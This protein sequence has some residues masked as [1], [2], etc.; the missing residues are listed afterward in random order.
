[1]NERLTALLNHPRTQAVLT[2]IRQWRKEL[3]VVLAMLLTM[4][5]P[6]LLKPAQSTAP[7]R[8]DR[9]LV[10]ISP[11]HDRIREEFGQAFAAHW[12]QST[13]QTLFIDWRVPGG[14]SEIAMLI[15]SE[16]S[17][18]FQQ[19]WQSK[20]KQAWSPAVAQAC[21]NPKAA[22]E[23]AARQAY[24]ASNLTT[25]MD[26]FFGGG[27]YDFEQQAK[28][29]TLVAGDGEKTG[30][31]GLTKKHPEWFGENGIPEKLSGEPFRDPQGRWCG[32]CLSSSGIVFNRD[33]LRRIGIA[34]DPDAWEDLADPRY[35]GQ[36]AL[37]DPGKSGS[38]TK[39]LEMLIQQQMQIAID[40]LKAVPN[41]KLTP[42]EL[43]AEG[44]AAGWNEGLRLILRISANARY[45]TDFSTKIPLEVARGDAGA[46]MCIDFYGRSAEEDVRKA[47]GTSR[48]GFIAPLGGTSIS[49]DPIGM[50]RGA[51]DPEIATAFIEFV[52]G[53]HGQK[54]WSF[55]VGEA[56]GPRQH[57]LRR[58][59]VRRD[60]YTPENIPRM[61]DGKEAPFEKAQAFTYHSERTGAAFNAIRFLVRVIC[62]DSHDELHDAWKRIIDNGMPER[63][64]TVLE[65]LTRV[66]YEAATGNIAKILAARDKAQETRLARELGDAFRNQFI[67]A[68]TIARR[69]S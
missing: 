61:S 27:A 21:L 51:P 54:L 55:R 62:V 11:H 20:L 50:L 26:V 60:L 40:R 30:I 53:E 52:L 42:E 3:A 43:E 48:V 69:G 6:F 37:S 45:F 56:G 10:I 38:V 31:S 36:I 41:A 16:A 44:V 7:A 47:D 57:A 64:I 13:G 58:L 34:D 2:W 46:G 17:A 59:P 67:R 63:A 14:T 23:D 68:G 33:V 4:I 28:A 29:G 25:G 49:V 35:Y 12:K 32:A 1:M 39:A 66:K 22:P 9:R 65:D 18:A 8:Y 15:K 19:H 24:L 5:G